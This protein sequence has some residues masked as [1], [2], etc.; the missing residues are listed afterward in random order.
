M[1][2]SGILYGHPVSQP[3]RSVQWYLDYSGNTTVERKVVDIMA[4]AHKQPDYV[5]KF[6]NHQVPGFETEDG[7]C[8]AESSAILKH[9]S[10]DDEKIKPQTAKD[11]ARLNEY[12]GRHYSQ[13]RKFSTEVFFH[14]LLTKDEEKKQAGLVAIKPQL[15]SYNEKLG[16]QKYI[17]GDKLTLADFLFAPEVD[18]ME[19]VGKEVLAP[20]QN[21]LKY[22]ER[23]TTDVKG[24][25]ECIGG[26]RSGL[27]E[28]LKMM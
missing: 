1:P 6:P 8:F 23:L 18:Q 2:A 17:L 27:E 7:F 3:C 22:L 9:V 26:M 28:M 12:F 24:Y 4:G 25:K 13:V 20:Y 10:R 5:A 16:K 14:H 15:E 19:A 21:I 11:E